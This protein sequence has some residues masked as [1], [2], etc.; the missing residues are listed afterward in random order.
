MDKEHINEGI[1]EIEQTRNDL[2]KAREVYFDLIKM[3]KMAH[4][5]YS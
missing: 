4:T 2:N 1:N 3:Q 5:K